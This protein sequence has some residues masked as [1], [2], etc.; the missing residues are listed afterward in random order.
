M[1]RSSPEVPPPIVKESTVELK[2][3]LRLPVPF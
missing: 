1:A 2:T 3:V